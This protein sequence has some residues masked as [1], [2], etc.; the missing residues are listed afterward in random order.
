MLSPSLLYVL[1]ACESETAAAA[2]A[3]GRTRR[4]KQKKGSDGPTEGRWSERA[5]E[6]RERTIDAVVLAGVLHGFVLL[7]VPPSLLPSLGLSS[8]ELSRLRTRA[9]TTRPRRQRQR[10]RRRRRQR[11]RRRRQQQPLLFRSF[12]R[13]RPPPPPPKQ[14]RH[15][16][17]VRSL[18][19]PPASASLVRRSLGPS[20]RR[21]LPPSLPLLSELAVS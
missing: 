3:A 11:W 10:R 14:A 15:V 21:S 18:R 20:V 5:S 1:C 4:W 8:P 13:V 12:L 2:A 6:R 17:Q 19:P 16:N 7:P 9:T